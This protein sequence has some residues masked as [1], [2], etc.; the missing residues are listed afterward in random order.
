MSLPGSRDEAM[1]DA[2]LAADA[3]FDLIA[4]ADHL[5][6]PRD[7]SV[8]GLDG[9]SMLAAWAVA[10]ERLRLSMLVSNLIYRQPVVLA[11]QVITVDQ[12]S[13]GRLDV[14]VGAGVYPT[15]HRMAGVPEWSP[16]ERVDRLEEFVRALDAALCGADSFQGDFYS[17]RDASWAPGP[18]QQPRPPILI[19]AVGPRMLRATARLA[20]V[21]S[22]FGGLALA[23]EAACFESLES[24][25][26]TLNAA[27]ES[28]G[29]D[30]ASLRRSLLAFRP[31]TPWARPGT[32][33]Q[34]ADSARRLG[35]DELVLYKPASADERRVFEDAIVGLPSLTTL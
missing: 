19:G 24:Q 26:R 3:G 28:I 23:D 34:I 13:G 32:L 35:F 25:A 11:K 9:W 17:F 33:E 16:R 14:G 8:P 1:S 21:W 7:T 4:T 18:L 15:D 2:R 5:R 6:H 30:P 29:R 10:T 20:D 27:C 22:A 12:L 31:L